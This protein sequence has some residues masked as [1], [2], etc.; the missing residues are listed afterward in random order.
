MQTALVVLVHN[1][2]ISM[3]LAVRRFAIIHTLFYF[4]LQL[5]LD[6]ALPGHLL[7][8]SDL[9]FAIQGAI[10]RQRATIARVAGRVE[11]EGVV[12]RAAK[13][14]FPRIFTL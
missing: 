11:G 1:E 12:G 3:A 9:L 6:F 4:G 10:V 8:G 13:H 2:M 5:V 14:L 7:Y